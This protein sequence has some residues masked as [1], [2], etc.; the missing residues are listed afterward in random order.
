MGISRSPAAP[1]C[2]GGLAMGDWGCPMHS[3]RQE[4]QCWRLGMTDR[5]LKVKDKYVYRQ[6]YRRERSVSCAEVKKHRS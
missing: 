1:H 2:T 6:T 4:Q 5:H 3:H